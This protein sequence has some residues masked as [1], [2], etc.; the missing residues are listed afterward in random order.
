M[1]TAAPEAKPAAT[2]LAMIPEPI[3]SRD[4]QWAIGLYN[5][6]S[7]EASVAPSPVPRFVLSFREAVRLQAR[8]NAAI[9]EVAALIEREREY[10]QKVQQAV[11]EAEA[12]NK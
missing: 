1:A 4:G 8:L 7:D 10:Q 6:E 11:E 3:K 9:D 5:D 12:E 2:D